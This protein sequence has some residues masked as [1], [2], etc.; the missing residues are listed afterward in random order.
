[1]ERIELITTDKLIDVMEIYRIAIEKM[2]EM[3][4]LQWNE[5]YPDRNIIHQDIENNSMFGYYLDW[6]FGGAYN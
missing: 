3:R 2:V 6:G 1:M 4:I 5:I